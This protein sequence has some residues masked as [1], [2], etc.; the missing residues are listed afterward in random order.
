MITQ[1]IKFLFIPIVNSIIDWKD[2]FITTIQNLMNGFVFNDV[3]N[4]RT[5]QDN[6][7]EGN[8]AQKDFK[9]LMNFLTNG[10][11]F[12]T[13]FIAAI[14]L[15]TFF[16]IV[17]AIIQGTGIGALLTAGIDAIPAIIMGVLGAVLVFGLLSIISDIFIE[18]I[19][20]VVSPIIPNPETFWSEG[21]VIGIISLFAA[22]I[23]YHR[24]ATAG[25]P[26]KAMDAG[27]LTDA[28]IGLFIQII[29]VCFTGDSWS[30]FGIGLIMCLISCYLSITG[31]LHTL[32]PDAYD[33]HVGN[34]FRYL[35]EITAGV[36][37]AY[38]IIS[39]GQY[40]YEYLTDE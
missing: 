35:E 20:T 28:I 24:A 40:I 3:E 13:I 21:I 37:A 14:A 32:K 36:S 27:G 29:G 22:I 39:T 8:N 5:R 2:D 6:G 12:I 31:F 17:V 34:P 9:N 26:A 1:T 11:F 10:K 18:V 19:K 4:T 30:I 15:E 23:S 7:N 38:S 16:A 25:K 33:A